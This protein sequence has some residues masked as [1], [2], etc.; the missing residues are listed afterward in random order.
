M[1]AQIKA[2]GHRDFHFADADMRL[3]APNNVL[4]VLDQ[5]FARVPRQ[6]SGSRPPLSLTVTFE[7]DLWHI[8]GISPNARKVLVGTS[9]P[10]QVAGAAVASLLADLASERSVS[11]WRAAIVEF[12]SNA[13]ALVGDDWESAITLAAHLHARGWRIVGG[14]YGLVDLATMNAHPFRKLL[15]VSSSSVASFPLAYRGAVEASPWYSSAH[16]IAFYAID[17]TL[18]NGTAAWGERSLITSVL[19]VDGRIAKQPSLEAGDNF[20]LAENLRRS[21]LPTTVNSAMLVLG[22]FIETADFLERWFSARTA[23]S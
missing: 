9:S 2:P 19:N 6:W 18:V 15:H 1:L 8:D 17:P 23:R 16:A 21:D 7:H 10:A 14:D 11:V 22:D 20:V 13:L 3:S 4:T 12:E 5:M